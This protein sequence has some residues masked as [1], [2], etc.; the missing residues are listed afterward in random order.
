MADEAAIGGGKVE[1]AAESVPTSAVQ[2]AEE[3]SKLPKIIR[4][5]PL[6]RGAHP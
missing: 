3:V 6:Y 2:S 1:V 4:S 5:S